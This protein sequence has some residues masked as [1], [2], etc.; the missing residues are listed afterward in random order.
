MRI[1]PLTEMWIYA[2]LLCSHHSIFSE[3]WLIFLEVLVTL[4]QV[5]FVQSVVSHLGSKIKFIQSQLTTRFPS[6]WTADLSLWNT[7]VSAHKSARMLMTEIPTKDLLSQQ[8]KTDKK[9]RDRLFLCGPPLKSFQVSLVKTALHVVSATKKSAVSCVNPRN[10]QVACCK[11]GARTPA[12]LLVSSLGMFS[13]QVE[14][15]RLRRESARFTLQ[16]CR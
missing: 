5:F 2:I 10:G 11:S 12:R 4:I 9:R 7:F 13:W 8:R 1:T 16:C 15:G 3:L 14:T 6:F